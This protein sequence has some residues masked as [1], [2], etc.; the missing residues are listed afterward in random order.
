[1]IERIDRDL[2]PFEGMKK[3]IYRE[4]NNDELSEQNF[5]ELENVI[6]ELDS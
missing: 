6:E 4:I 3:T 1:M 5:N 2:D